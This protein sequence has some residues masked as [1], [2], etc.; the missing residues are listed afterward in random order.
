MFQCSVPS[1]QEQTRLHV[2]DCCTEGV[3]EWAQLPGRLFWIMEAKST[4]IQNLSHL[5]GAPTVG[6][7]MMCRPHVCLSPLPWPFR[8]VSLL[9]PIAP[10][11]P[12]SVTNLQDFPPLVFDYYLFIYLLI[13]GERYT[14]TRPG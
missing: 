8:A 5:K 10:G 7:F 9:V 12:L 4:D 14:H 11:K 2:C 13:T 3:V 1:T 6:V